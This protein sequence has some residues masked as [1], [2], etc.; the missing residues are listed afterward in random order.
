[1]LYV[2]QDNLIIYSEIGIMLVIKKLLG[3]INSIMIN[4]IYLLWEF[5][6]VFDHLRTFLKENWWVKYFTSCI[7]IITPC[8]NIH[9][10]TE[11]AKLWGAVNFT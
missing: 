4:S 9:N 2:R 7:W 1:M 6:A 11:G 5:Y 3:L 8:S 10:G